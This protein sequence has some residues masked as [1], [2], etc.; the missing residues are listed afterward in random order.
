MKFLPKLPNILTLWCLCFFFGCQSEEIA[1][2]EYTIPATT[3]GIFAEPIEI[4][5][6]QPPIFLK[7]SELNSDNYP[8]LIVTTGVSSFDVSG[9][10]GTI[11]VLTSNSS[12]RPT[13]ASADFFEQTA[14]APSNASI[15]YT[16]T[17][18]N[19]NNDT[20]HD[21]LVTDG[22]NNR[23]V[24]YAGSTSGGVTRFAE[25]NTSITQLNNRPNFMI[26]EDWD[27]DGKTDV[28]LTY[29]DNSTLSLIFQDNATNSFPMTPQWE[30]ST[31]FIEPHQITSG[32]WNQDSY[33]DIALIDGDKDKVYLLMN[34]QNKSFSLQ[35]TSYDIEGAPQAVIAGDWDQDGNQDLAVTV[36]SLK[37]V[38]LLYGVGSGSF[39]QVIV[40]VEKGPIQIA[41]TNATA[42]WNA[43]GII[44]FVVG[45][46]FVSS[47][48][49][50]TGDLTLLTST[51]NRSYTTENIGATTNTRGSR[52][53]YMTVD[54]FNND[55]K[56]DIAVSLPMH[57]KVSI[58]LQNK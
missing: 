35:E 14:L 47:T 45:N 26:A 39:T 23:T 42:D 43:D 54:D 29:F 15:R 33:P 10:D 40:N 18:G 36:F 12:S 7:S 56:N 28:A 50:W 13:T 31:N 17:N 4:S 38:N 3:Y 20:I 49:E 30:T 53:S 51:G 58:L 5:I 22:T 32:D 6:S 1:Q 57:K 37:Q 9:A 2:T 27:Q 34:S 24:L 41:S 55:G 8:D 48:G 21:L 25:N 16:F 19:F 44:D 46:G 52:P 11:Y